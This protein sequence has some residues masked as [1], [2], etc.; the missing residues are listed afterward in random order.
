MTIHLYRA[1]AIEDGADDCG[2][3]IFRG[4]VLGSRV[5]G[6]LSRSSAMDA[7]RASGVEFEVERSEPIVFLSRRERLRKRAAELSAEAK[8]LREEADACE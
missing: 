7:G 1:V 3:P 4:E 5:S 6:Y 8:A 2:E